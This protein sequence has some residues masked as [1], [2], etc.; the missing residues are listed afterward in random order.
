MIKH[1]VLF[2][3]KSFESEALKTAKQEEIKQGLLALDGKVPSLQ[4]IEVGLNCNPNETFD[5]ALSTTFNNMDDMHAYAQHP[6]HLAVGKIV[7]EVLESR[8]CVD[9]EF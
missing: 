1:I 7:R 9:Y 3:L 8:S 4:S 6:D 5:I 2:K